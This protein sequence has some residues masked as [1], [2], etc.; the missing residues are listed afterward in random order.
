MAF[1]QFFQNVHD[2]I[3]LLGSPPVQAL[4]RDRSNAIRQLQGDPQF[5]NEQQLLDAK[6]ALE[7]KWRIHLDECYEKI[8]NT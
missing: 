5:T 2:A 3:N 4:L 7:Q 6:L 1:F 8:K